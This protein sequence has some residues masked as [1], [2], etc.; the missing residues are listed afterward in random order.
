[1][2]FDHNATINSTQ[3]TL[4]RDPNSFL[5]MGGGHFSGQQVGNNPITGAHGIPRDFS[6]NRTPGR[7]ASPKGG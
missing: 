3:S 4:E 6:G 7:D 2:L 1:M 5:E